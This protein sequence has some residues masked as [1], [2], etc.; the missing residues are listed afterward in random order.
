[1]FLKIND[2][3]QRDKLVNEFLK[4]RKNIKQ[5]FE[6]Q[7]LTEMGFKEDT[8]K[9]FKPITESVSQ[10][11]QSQNS[12]LNLVL[13]KL[14]DNKKLLVSNQ[15]KIYEKLKQN[16]PAITGSKSLTVSRLIQNYL[17]D[18]SIERSNAGYSIRFDPK[19]NSYTIGDSIINFEDNILEI[20][21]KK[22][23][24]TEGLLELLTKKDPDEDLCIEEDYE[25]Y[26]EILTNTN[27]IY[28]NFDRLSNKVYSDRSAKWSIIK[29][30]LF[31]D[32]FK[33]KGGKLKN[34]TFLSSD[35]VNLINQLRL[36]ISSRIAGNNG[37]FNKINA[38]LDELLRQ[39]IISKSDF[40]KIHRNVFGN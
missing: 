33:K 32:L 14:D 31:R 37:E 20:A 6:Q 2:P 3:K 25:D 22:Y 16:L 9:L 1:M 39:K 26:K 28:H 8:Q 21:G 13:N 23:N 27:A 15:G 38:I 30:K 34:I 40:I 18:T 10:N 29:N 19:Y 35:P 24:A 5:N 11:I 4:T 36:S 7:K 17:S 12:N